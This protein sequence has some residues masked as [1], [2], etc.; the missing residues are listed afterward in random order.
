M[1]PFYYCLFILLVLLGAGCKKAKTAPA[2]LVMQALVGKY[3]WASYHALVNI[4]KDPTLHLSIRADSA[5]THF[6]LD[7]GNYSGIGTYSL[8]D[9]SNLATYTAYD[10]VGGNVTQPLRVRL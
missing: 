6:Q 10:P 3:N 9:S 1:R 4:S 8:Y 2:T 7:V 5:N